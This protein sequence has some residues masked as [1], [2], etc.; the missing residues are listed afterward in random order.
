MLSV[1]EGAPRRPGG[2]DAVSHALEAAHDNLVLHIEK[3]S[4]AELRPAVEQ[5]ARVILVELKEAIDSYKP[6]PG[7]TDRP[8][9]G[10]PWDKECG[11]WWRRQA[12]RGRITAGRRRVRRVSNHVVP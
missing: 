6:C 8:N 3:E 5:L 4:L 12:Y 7:A 10:S 11:H 1:E 9:G 2:F